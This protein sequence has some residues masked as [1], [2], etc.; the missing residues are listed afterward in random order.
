M[1]TTIAD[2]GTAQDG[3]EDN[4]LFSLVRYEEDWSSL[5]NSA[6]RTHWLDPLKYIRLGGDDRYLTLGGET[7]QRYEFFNNSV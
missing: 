2:R 7:R 4:S 5:R 1:L 3:K 6:S